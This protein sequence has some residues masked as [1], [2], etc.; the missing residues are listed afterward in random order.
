[1]GW[2]NDDSGGTYNSNSQT[3][4]KTLMLNSSLF[5][6]MIYKYFEIQDHQMEKLKYK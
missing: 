4:F 6:I 1:M 3:E 2:N 5:L